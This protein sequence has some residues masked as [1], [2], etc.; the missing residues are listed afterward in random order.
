MAKHGGGWEVG[1]RN[2]KPVRYPSKARAQKVAR[3]VQGAKVRR[4][5]GGGGGG[6]SGNGCLIAIVCGSAVLV[7]SALLPL[8]DGASRIAGVA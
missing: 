8:V 6:S 7:L 4:A 5:G 3:Q 1:G 2:I